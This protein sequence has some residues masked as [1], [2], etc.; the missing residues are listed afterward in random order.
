MGNSQD[1]RSLQAL[2]KYGKG[3][4]E[5]NVSELESSK[6][7]IRSAFQDEGFDDVE[8]MIQA[9]TKAL[10]AAKDAFPNIDKHLDAYA[11]FLEEQGN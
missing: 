2:L 4:V 11:S 7:T 5:Q 3:A 10:D 1:V 9:I 8:K 6:N